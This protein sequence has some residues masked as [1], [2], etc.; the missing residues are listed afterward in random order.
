M[1]ISAN[2][3]IIP[4]DFFSYISKEFILWFIMYI[5]NFITAIKTF[6]KNF[7]WS[8]IYHKKK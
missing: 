7:E 2:Y 8:K 6:K 5:F 4:D 3:N 1:T